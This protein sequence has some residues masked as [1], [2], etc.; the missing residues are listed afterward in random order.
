MDAELHQ[1]A[2][3]NIRRLTR[4]AIDALPVTHGW[5]EIGYRDLEGLTREVLKH[6]KDWLSHPDVYRI[7]LTHI[8]KGLQDQHSNEQNPSGRLVDLLSK[9]AYKNLTECISQF[10][11]SIP[12][13]YLVYLPLPSLAGV[14]IE[15]L[16]LRPGILIKASSQS[17]N[18][19][20]QNLLMMGFLGTPQHGEQQ[21]IG[22]SY[23]CVKAMG[24]S[25]GYLGDSATEDALRAFKVLLH[26]GLTTKLLEVD[27][28]RQ[29]QNVDWGYFGLGIE[30]P[31]HKI[32]KIDIKSVDQ[33][34]DKET[35]IYTELPLDFTRFVQS[36][37]FHRNNRVVE[38]AKEGKDALASLLTA[39]FKKHAWLL[40]QQTS[41][42]GSIKLAIE[43]GINSRIVENKTLSFIQ[44]CI[45]LES[46]LGEDLEEGQG[47]TASLADR[48]AYLLAKGS[49]SRKFA[50]KQFKELYKLRSNLVH[51]KGSKWNDDMDYSR[52]WGETILDAAIAKE[53][54][55]LK[56]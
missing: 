26:A 30:Q 1:E 5:P 41:E 21:A 9:S 4:D 8:R 10:L 33:T 32:P 43:W 25:G 20:S 19:E 51:G 7:F 39:E 55:S 3:K 45:A 17:K 11:I 12:R 49:K 14:E 18:V 44:T 47:L 16:E 56:M 36:I 40:G 29:P 34:D 6:K 35:V 31:Q 22:D 46:I 52:H 50:R 2:A 42:T 53:L 38:K 13:E 27:K 28:Y 54:E 48:C 23:F 37:Y 24:Y 15:P